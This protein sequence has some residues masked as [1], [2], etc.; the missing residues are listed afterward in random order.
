LLLLLQ[1]LLMLLLKLLLLV[2]LIE[3]LVAGIGLKLLY[4]C[5]DSCRLLLRSSIAQAIGGRRSILE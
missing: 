3:L 5:L 4:G 1:L 2:L